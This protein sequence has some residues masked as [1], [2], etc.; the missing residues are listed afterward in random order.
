ML[1]EIRCDKFM[2]NGKPR[3]PICF[4]SGLNVVLGSEAGDNSIGKSTFL[5]IVD[6]VF[7]GNDY[8]MKSTDVQTNVLEHTIQ[9]A[10]EFGDERHH[11]SRETTNHTVVWKCNSSYE[12]LEE[13][14]LQDFHQHLRTLYG[15]DLYETTFRDIIGRYFRVYGRDN[16]DEKEPLLADKK[17]GQATAIRSLMKLF[18]RYRAVAE[19]T[20]A[21]K[22]KNE[23]RDAHKK[24]QKHKFIPSITK[25][26][27]KKNVKRLAELA[28]ELDTFQEGIEKDLLGLDSKEAEI[29]ADFK[30]KLSN[31]KRNK[32]RL[33]SQLRSIENDMRFGSRNKLGADGQLML[34]PDFSKLARFF[35]NV[36]IKRIEEIE[37]FHVEM[38]SVLTSEFE[39]AKKSLTAIIDLASK[40]ILELEQKIIESG[41]PAKLSAKVLNSFAEKK[42]ETE[43][44]ERENTAHETM[45]VLKVDAKELSDKLAHMQAEQFVTVHTEVNIKMN[46]LNDFIYDGEKKSPALNIAKANNYTFYTPDDTG[47]GTSYKGLVVFDLSILALTPLPAIIHDSV[48]LKQ[49]ADEP[50]EKIMK[51][52]SNNKKQ[53]FVAIDKKGSYTSDTQKIIEDKI[54]LHLSPNGNELFGRSWNEKQEEIT[55]KNS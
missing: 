20:A 10:F 2:S 32:T 24:A 34:L 13:M 9:F 14:R 44:L 45:D 18:D 22:N 25:T 17:E 21:V 33:L 28:R 49:I 5:M 54:V 38:T 27:Y 4:Q 8:V 12:K 11:F 15:I 29:V 53:V 37:Q 55:A 23:E 51:L 46:E 41:V 40:E 16:L 36:D 1:I 31:A 42:N 30:Q 43:R 39:T 7:G 6:F 19:L 50:L 47:T 35:P 48:A 26:V 52:Y 3:E